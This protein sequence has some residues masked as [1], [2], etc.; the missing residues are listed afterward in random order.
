MEEDKQK[1]PRGEGGKKEYYE[2]TNVGDER[3]EREREHP[4][5][6]VMPEYRVAMSIAT[7]EYAT[8][9]NARVY[10]REEQDECIRNEEQERKADADECQRE[11]EEKDRSYD[12]YCEAEQYRE[13]DSMRTRGCRALDNRHSESR[14]ESRKKAGEN[15]GPQDAHEKEEPYAHEREDARS[16]DVWQ[17]RGVRVLNTVEY[18]CRRGDYRRF[19]RFVGERTLNCG[20]RGERDS[21]ARDDV[22]IAREVARERNGIA[23]DGDRALGAVGQRRIRG[24]NENAPSR[25]TGVTHG[26]AECNKIALHRFFNGDAPSHRS[27]ITS[28]TGARI[29]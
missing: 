25:A 12:K 27:E 15:E 28:D 26:E 22:D 21:T 2:G 7:C 4:E 13:K 17:I 20:A 19:G 6:S 16:T 24:D 1:R 5:H 14:E 10:E 8:E 3:E 23:I 11:E 9:Q 29:Y 18:Y